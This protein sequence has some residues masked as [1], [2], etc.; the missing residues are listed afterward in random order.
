MSRKNIATLAITLAA[1]FFMLAQAA[2]AH[3][4]DP[5]VGGVWS[6]FPAGKKVKRYTV[7]VVQRGDEFTWSTPD[8]KGSGRV[9]GRTVTTSYRTP[10][11]PK[12]I[13]GKITKMGPGNVVQLIKWQNGAVWVRDSRAK[14]GP[15]PE[16]PDRPIKPLSPYDYRKRPLG[17]RGQ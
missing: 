8:L 15:Q 14:L 4:A 9:A 1:V 12:T 17:T 16:P 11:G 13:T 5:Q 3:A 6:H 7:E 10:R 2:L